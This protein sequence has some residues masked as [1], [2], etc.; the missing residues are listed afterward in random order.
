MGNRASVSFKQGD[1]ESV[2]LFSHWGGKEFHLEAEAYAR[3]LTGLQQGEIRF[4]L[5]RLEPQTVMVDFI[6]S[7]T[8]DLP[9]VK[10]N[11]YLGCSP[12]DGD[13]S[14]ADHHVVVLPNRD[15]VWKELKHA[16]I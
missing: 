15:F 10:S 11:F 1:K 9:C 12:E 5:D 6:R 2:T 7:L 14:D 3:A 16:D 13:N 4:P 8:K